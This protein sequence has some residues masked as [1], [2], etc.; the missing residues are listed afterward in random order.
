MDFAATKQ[1]QKE[2][3]AQLRDVL[4]H[5]KLDAFLVP[6]TDEYMNEYVPAY[7]QRLAWLTGFTGSA[8]LAIV[9][10][11]RAALFTDGRYT[12]QAAQQVDETLYELLH[13]SKNPLSEYL[14]K[15]LKES[16]RIAYDPWL[17]TRMGLEKIK[18]ALA[19]TKSKI[20]SVD[21][22]LID[23]I[24]LD[25]PAPPQAQVFAHPLR[26]SGEASVAKRERLTKELKAQGI[27]A[28]VITSPPSI[29]WLLNVRGA[30]VENTPLPLSYAIL[31]GNG[32]VDWFV[33]PEKLNDALR[34]EMDDGISYHPPEAF[35]K[36]MKAL[37]ARK[38][39]VR[40]DAYH[41]PSRVLDMLEDAGA[42][43][44][45]GL[46]PCEL[47]KACKN[48]QEL[49]GMKAAHLRDG[50]QL[51]RFL[52]WLAAQVPGTV[53]EIMAEQKLLEFR[54]QSPEFLYPSFPSISGAGPNGAIVHYRATMKTNRMLGAG[55]LYLIDS[56][57]QYHDGT[58]DVTRTVAIASPSSAM[59]RHFTLVL[60]GYI[61]L[62]RACFP[63]GTHGGQLDV[64]AR[65][66]LWREGL[67]YD[68]GTG[69][70]VGAF[71]GVHEGPQGISGRST[72]PLR[73]GMVVSNEPGYYL[74][75]A[76]GIRIENLVYVK[77]TEKS[78]DGKPMLAFESLTLAPIDL[79]LIDATLLDREEKN[80][81]NAYHQQVYVAHQGHLSE[82]EKNWLN[83]A[84]R[85]L[86]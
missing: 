58:T 4:A 25:K 43:I 66:A 48:T 9:M 33:M 17:H 44:D 18:P 80:W 65:Q 75:G 8:G 62:A 70:G 72:V 49:E 86:V 45:A 60:K 20:I 14:A 36:A 71:L 82:S 50:L 64:L 24:W 85:G 15:Y 83:A 37:G 74:A 31:Y 23:C 38:A 41:T 69:H 5:E 76:Y 32:A 26:Y 29:A 77:E 39:R 81:L 59:K 56:G 57:G 10:A 2:R 30:D 7:A 51:T 47:P 12:L 16:G 73:A 28:S 1:Q 52:C 53:N 46:D 21:K 40:I 68:H 61:A 19:K 78:L 84:T 35:S 54:K 34:R 11:D 55:E 22:N 42:V 6:L 27:D 3:I 63:Q 13:T 67:D 79:N